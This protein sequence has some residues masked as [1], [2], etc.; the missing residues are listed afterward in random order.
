M[1]NSNNFQNLTKDLY[2]IVGGK[3]LTNGEAK[4]LLEKIKERNV[5]GYIKD[6]GSMN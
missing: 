5:D 2:I 6:A 1:L 3:N 4:Q